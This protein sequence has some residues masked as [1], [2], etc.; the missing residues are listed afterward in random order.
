LPGIKLKTKSGARPK[1]RIG[2]RKTPRFCRIAREREGVNEEKV[3]KKGGKETTGE[4]KEE[5][6]T[7][8]GCP[9]REEKFLKARSFPSRV[10]KGRKKK[11]RFFFFGGG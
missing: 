5:L 2:K 1:R 10:K 6:F 9:E 7:K 8:K 4:E 3:L 11:N